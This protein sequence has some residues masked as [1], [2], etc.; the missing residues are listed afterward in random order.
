MLQSA[1]PTGKPTRRR[2]YKLFGLALI[3]LTFALALPAG[4]SAYRSSDGARAAAD[5]NIT[6]TVTNAS[7]AGLP[8][9]GVQADRY[10][11]PGD[12]EWAG[13]TQTT[14]DGTYDLGG[15]PT[16]NYH[17]TFKDS[18]DYAM[19]YYDNKSSMDSA[20]D[21]AVTAGQTTPGIDAVLTLAGH[22]S[23]TVTNASAAG[24][25]GIGVE[26]SR[27]NGP[28]DWGWAGYTQTTADGAYDLGGL[29][30][31]SYVIEFRDDAGAYATQY[32]D[33]KPTFEA[34]DDVAVTAPA[35]TSGIDA[36]L[37][38]AAPPAVTLKLSGLKSGAIKLGK[39]VTAS[40]AVTPASLAGKVTLTVQLKKG[41]TWIKAKTASVT[42]IFGGAYS[43]K[44]TP[45]KKGAYQM[46]AKIA[47][48]DA[49]AAATSKWL[50]FK[51]K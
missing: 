18:S 41:S 5:G 25:P 23:G 12:W 50:T 48:T 9:I 17:I 35:T 47:K 3:L 40:G 8:G 38:A 31:G 37:V 10:N 49:H 20:D 43:W 26:A 36:T 51:V 24:L 2:A 44:Y 28:G 46:Q 27:Y 42:I 1:T 4:A 16:G 21:V 39:S 45:A 32:Y 22:I 11:G 29:P 14:A 15:L 13:Y 6:G 7:A 34:A 33:N 30:T 19:Q